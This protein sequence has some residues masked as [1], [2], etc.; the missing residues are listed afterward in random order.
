[1]RNKTRTYVDEMKPFV[2]SGG[3]LVGN[4]R[5]LRWADLCARK[6]RLTDLRRSPWRKSASGGEMLNAESEMRKA[7]RDTEGP[8]QGLPR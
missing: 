4:G 1:M 6:V 7:K 8:N 3:S 5:P 2:E